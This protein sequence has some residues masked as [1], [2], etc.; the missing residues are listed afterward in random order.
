MQKTSYHGQPGAGAARDP[1]K[2][3]TTVPTDGTEEEDNGRK[4]QK[5]G[6]GFNAPGF[7]SAGCKDFQAVKPG[8][9]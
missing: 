4:R 5:P 1:G 9:E 3:G 7:V 8:L 2:Q 6:S